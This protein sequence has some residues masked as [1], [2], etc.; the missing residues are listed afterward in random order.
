MKF[1]T[2]ALIALATAVVAAPQEVD[3]KRHYL[4]DPCDP[5]QETFACLADNPQVFMI[6][7]TVYWETMSTCPTSATCQNGQ[8]RDSDGDIVF[9]VDPPVPD[10]A[11]DV[12]NSK[13]ADDDSTDTQDDSDEGDGNKDDDDKEDD[14]DNKDDALESF[15]KSVK[16][17]ADTRSITTQRVLLSGAASI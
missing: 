14:E 11:S 13:P 7:R 17:G 12:G 6:C 8:C 1:I 10:Y 9:P 3:E 15:F 16:G 2:P 4:G 5:K